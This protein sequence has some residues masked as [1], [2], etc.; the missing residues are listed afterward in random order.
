MRV[1]SVVPWLISDLTKLRKNREFL[2]DG[3]LFSCV[4]LL[5]DGLVSQAEYASICLLKGSF[6]TGLWVPCSQALSPP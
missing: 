1:L 3:G 4:L 6:R 5:S 2:G